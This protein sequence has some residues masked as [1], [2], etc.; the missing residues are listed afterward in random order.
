MTNNAKIPRSLVWGNRVVFV[1]G[2]WVIAG[3]SGFPEF[4]G[5][6]ENMEVFEQGSGVILFKALTHEAVRYIA[7]LAA[8][9]V[10]AKE[11]W[12]QKDLRTRFKT[13]VIVLLVGIGFVTLFF[14]FNYIYV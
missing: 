4:R 1:L 9:A 11:V 10:I 6:L 5:F 2:L 13:N 12:L 7:L 8:L 3:T 14:V